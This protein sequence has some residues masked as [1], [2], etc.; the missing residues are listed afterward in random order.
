[1]ERTRRQGC[2]QV[3]LAAACRSTSH[4]PAEIRDCGHRDHDQHQH[5]QHKSA[6]AGTITDTGL[7]SPAAGRQAAQDGT[8][9]LRTSVP[10]E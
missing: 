10:A 3:P 7:P 4:Q 5:D 8:Y 2:H 9:V 6:Q 1:M